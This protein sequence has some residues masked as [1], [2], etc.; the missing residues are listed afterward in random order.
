MINFQELRIT[1]NDE[2]LIIDVVI[3]SSDYYKDVVLDSIVIDTQDTYIDN[4][5]SENYVYRYT[6][7]EEDDNKHIRLILTQKEIGTIKNNMFFVYVITT[8]E[9]ADE[10]VLD[11]NYKSVGVVFNTY[12][13]YKESMMYTKEVAC[14][15]GIPKKFIDYIL[16]LKVLEIAVRTG[17]YQEAIRYWNKLFRNSINTQCNCYGKNN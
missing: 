16:K 17:N 2:H 1:P 14:G 6:L 9:P 11:K 3:D 7:T 8:G 10:S 15:C 4:G 12:P 13:I 5:A